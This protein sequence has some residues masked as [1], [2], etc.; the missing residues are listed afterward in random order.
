MNRLTCVLRIAGACLLFT[1]GVAQA[2]GE[3]NPP[4]D[5]QERAVP[6]QK[7]QGPQTPAGRF[8]LL[9]ASPEPPEMLAKRQEADNAQRSIN[10]GRLTKPQLRQVLLTHPDPTIRTKAQQATQSVGGVPMPSCL[11]LN[12]GL[13]VH[14]MQAWAPRE[15]NYSQAPARSDWTATAHVRRW[16]FPRRGPSFQSL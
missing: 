5:V 15:H 7:G 16:D 9:P 1:V 11:P 2:E 6:M 8:Q 4:G 12:N 10:Q 14:P 13:Q 3:P